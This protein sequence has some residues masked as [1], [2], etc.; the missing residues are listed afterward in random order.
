MRKQ[1]IGILFTATLICVF[2]F[3]TSAQSPNYSVEVECDDEI[4]EEVSSEQNIVTRYI[5]RTFINPSI[6]LKEKIEHRRSRDTVIMEQALLPTRD[7]ST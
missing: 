1:W 5:G 2:S 4:I 7:T 3:T 6:Y